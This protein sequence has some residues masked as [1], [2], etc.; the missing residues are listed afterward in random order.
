MRTKNMM[1][2]ALDVGTASAELAHRQIGGAHAESLHQRQ[3][4]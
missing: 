1:G 3:A 4:V 2:G